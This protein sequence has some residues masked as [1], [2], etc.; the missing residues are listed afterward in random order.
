G[1]GA[2]QGAVAA[3]ARLQHLGFDATEADRLPVDDPLGGPY[4]DAPD[5]APWLARRHQRSA[6]VPG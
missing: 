5:R 3:A 1:P 2:G 4:D 6:T